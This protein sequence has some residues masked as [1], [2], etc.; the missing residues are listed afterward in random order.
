MITYSVQEL[1]AVLFETEINHEAFK[2]NRRKPLRDE[3]CLLG[4]VDEASHSDWWVSAKI[5]PR[6]ALK[7]C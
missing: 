1:N 3:N 5:I 4:A 6:P 7:T 2:R